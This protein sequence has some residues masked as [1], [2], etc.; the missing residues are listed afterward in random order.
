MPAGTLVCDCG[1]IALLAVF[2]LVRGWASIGEFAMYKFFV[3]MLIAPSVVL[4]GLLLWWLLASRLRWYDRLLVVGTFVAV[5]TVTLVAADPSF[6]SVALAMY[7][8]PIV[9]TAWPGWLAISFRFPWPVRRAGVFWSC[10][11]GDRLCV[12]AYRWLGRRFC[13]QVQLALDPHARAETAWGT[14]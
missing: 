11:G 13:R 2:W 10:R 8:L 6:R 5:T 9:V 1:G 3:S 12:V 7:A 4:L 14:G